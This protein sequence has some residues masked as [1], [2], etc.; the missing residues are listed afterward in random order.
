MDGNW[1][2]VD[3]WGGMKEGHVVMAPFANMP[4]D[5]KAAAEAAVE[6][7]KGGFEPF[8]GPVAKQDGSEWLKDGERAENGVLLGLKFYVTGGDQKLPL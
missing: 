4:D 8:T 6:K 2:Q 5:V 3:V 1:S 7:I